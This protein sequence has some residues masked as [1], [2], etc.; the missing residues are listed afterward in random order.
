MKQG[1]NEET[2]LLLRGCKAKK[3]QNTLSNEKIKYT[4]SV[5]VI[6]LM[7]TFL[8]TYVAIYTWR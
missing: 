5:I 7:Y 4:K 8:F 3:R 6:K 2:Q 1:I